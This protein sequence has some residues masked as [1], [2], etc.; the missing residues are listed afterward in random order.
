MKSIMLGLL[1][2]LPLIS[3]SFATTGS[4]G[5][6]AGALN[7]TVSPQT[8]V[9]ILQNTFNYSLPFTVVNAHINN[10][11]ITTSVSNG[12]IPPNSLFAI[13][14]TVVSYTNKSESGFITAYTSNSSSGSGGAH[15]RLGATKQI[16]VNTKV[17][18][19]AP[20]STISTSS[21]IIPNQSSNINAQ[22]QNLTQIQSGKTTIQNNS[23]NQSSKLGQATLPG[24]SS[25]NT[26][27]VIAVMALVIAVLAAWVVAGAV[28][29]KKRKSQKRRST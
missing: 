19:P 16:N 4:F 7:Y 8:H 13:N 23:S 14:V 12:I 26:A 1:V 15:I 25:N 29:K 24:S 20:P 9:W 21:T 6:V 22:P 27:L 10:T 17:P 3:L 2:L 11:L 5:E 18:S 28:G